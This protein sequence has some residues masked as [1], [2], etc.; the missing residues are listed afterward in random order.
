[1]TRVDEGNIGVLG[2]GPEKGSHRPT[3]EAGKD[4]GSWALVGAGGA[5]PPESFS[6]TPARDHSTCKGEFEKLTKNSLSV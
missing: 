6:G 1:M 5:W 2:Q 3:S 4:L